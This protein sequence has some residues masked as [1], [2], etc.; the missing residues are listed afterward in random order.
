MAWTTPKTWAAAE[1]ATAANLN[2]HVRDNL[3]YLYDQAS[4]LMLGT[5][6]TLGAPAATLAVTGLA[7]TW[8]ILR[9]LIYARSVTAATSDTMRIR[10]GGG[11]LDTTATNYFSYTHT[12]STTTPTHSVSEN[13]GATAGIGGS[14]LFV[15]GNTATAS[16]FAL[17]EVVVFGGSVSAGLKEVLVTAG[18]DQNLDTTGN[19]AIV[20]GGG[21]WK[22]T[23]NTLQQ[24]SCVLTSAANFATGSWISIYGG[25]C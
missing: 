5:R 10:F 4:F 20:R 14:G 23:A 2:L 24:V 18:Y 22:N 16:Y 6:T 25:N 17:Y 19:L 21:K 15:P 11:A 8:E 3:A 9:I 7:V 13:L 12:I 1:L